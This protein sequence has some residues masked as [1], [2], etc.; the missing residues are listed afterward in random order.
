MLKCQKEIN[1]ISYKWQNS[2]KFSKLVIYKTIIYYFSHFTRHQIGWLTKDL[3]KLLFWP[4]HETLPKQLQCVL[5]QTDISVW[6]T[7]EMSFS[8]YTYIHG[9][10]TLWCSLHYVTDG[11]SLVALNFGRSAPFKGKQ[12]NK[13]NLIQKLDFFLNLQKVLLKRL[14]VSPRRK[15]ALFW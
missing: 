2:H 13:V 3:L 15:I 14:S 9:D 8:K 5:E 10:I 6:A 4:I 11:T 12:N 7:W 1:N